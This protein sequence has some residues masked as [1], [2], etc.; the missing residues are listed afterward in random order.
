MIGCNSDSIILNDISKHM[1]FIHLKVS[2]I[3]CG[4]YELLKSYLLHLALLENSH[5][6][7][8]CGKF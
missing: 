7:N 4:F 2:I 8:N 6:L 1:Y 3:T 5:I